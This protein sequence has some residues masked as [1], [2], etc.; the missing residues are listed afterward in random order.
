MNEVQKALR[1][2]HPHSF[3]DQTDEWPDN[4]VRRTSACS[5]KINHEAART[6]SL[7]SRRGAPVEEHDLI[8]ANPKHLHF[9][10]GLKPALTLHRNCQIWGDLS[11]IELTAAQLSHPY[12]R[13]HGHGA[14]NA[15]V[16]KG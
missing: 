3:Q 4:H 12:G 11:A 9:V 8:P 10:D 5:V 15:G 6:R 2:F 7:N 13:V 14:E 16:T 1:Q